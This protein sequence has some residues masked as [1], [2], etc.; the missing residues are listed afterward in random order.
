MKKLIEDLISE[1]F[2]KTPRIINA[3]LHIDRIDFVSEELKFEAYVNAPL[4][5]GFGQ[6]IS[7]PAT[8]AFMLELLDPSPGD[9]ILDIGSGSG[10]QSALLAFIVSHDDDGEELN[11]NKKG[12]IISIELIPELESMGRRNIFK[13]NFIKK[14]IVETHCLNATNGFSP[15]AP[16]QKIIAAASINKIPEEWKRQLKTYGSIVAPVDSSLWRYTKMRDGSFK[17][18][19]FPGFTF[20]P[21][22]KE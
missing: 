12:K 22:V 6:T 4:P 13:Y 9:K 2:L 15:E 17:E 14:G 7:Q 8:V 11:Q 20:V 19:E 18:E 1:G 3:F 5:I 16:Y 10:W 21:F